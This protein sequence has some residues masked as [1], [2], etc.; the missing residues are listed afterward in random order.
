[1]S[2]VIASA[3]EKQ[4]SPTLFDLAPVNNKRVRLDFCAPKLSAF[5]GLAAIREHEHSGGIID[6]IVTCI[7]D[8]RN[9]DFVVHS[10][11]EMVRQR[12]YQIIAGYE[13][14]DDC[15]RLRSDGMLKLCAG[16]KPS[17][18][19]DLASQPTMCRLENKLTKQELYAIGMAFID[20]FIASYASAPETI[21]IDAD[22]TNANTFG[23]QQLTLFNA[24]YGEYCYMPLLLFEGQSGKMI[25]PILRPGRTNKSI[26][27]SGWL[28]RLITLLRKKWP[29]V[30]IIFRGD[31]Q[32]C[33]HQFMDWVRDNRQK[34]VRFIT[35]LAGN[36]K[37]LEKV[38]PWVEQAKAHYKQTGQEIRQ[39]HS[40]LH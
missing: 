12:V 14:A 5:G 10:Y 27:I 30:K 31:S 19:I 23:N 36:V 17:D 29:G 34:Q 6:R 13:D 26:N 38:A 25:L 28:I 18:E 32:F 24:Y 9:Q 21:V 2:K 35:G 1:M 15:N 22:D 11:G 8:L 7:V 3:A 40:F 16:R 20:N 4:A 39:F 33:S 37:L